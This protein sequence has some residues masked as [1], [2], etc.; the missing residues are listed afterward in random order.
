MRATVVSVLFL[1]FAVSP[2]LAGAPLKGVDVKLGK[3]PGGKP[4]ARIT[5]NAGNYTFSSGNDGGAKLR[6]E[7]RVDGLNGPMIKR[8]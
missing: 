6:I 2:V 3:N 1:A 8:K 5:V 4:A 7:H